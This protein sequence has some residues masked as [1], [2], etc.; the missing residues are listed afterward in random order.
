M[1]I[2]ARNSRRPKTARVR[3]GLF[4]ELHQLGPLGVGASPSDRS[5]AGRRAWSETRSSSAM[6]V[7]L[8]TSELPAVG[9]ERRGQAGQR[10]QPRD[11]ADDDEHL[12]GEG[13]ASPVASSLPKPSRQTRAARSA[14]STIST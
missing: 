13:T 1:T 14:R 10:D 9:E 5:G 6:I 2:R 3:I 7:Q 11:P 12:E 8:A 4:T